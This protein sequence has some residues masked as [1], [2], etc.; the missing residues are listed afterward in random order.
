MAAQNLDVIRG[1][2]GDFLNGDFAGVMNRFDEQIEWVITEN[3]P[4]GGRF[5]GHEQVAAFFQ[6]L[7]QHYEELRVE[8]DEFVADGD[9][10]V[11][12]GVHRGRTRVGNEFEI[13]F[14]HAWML[15]D[16]K[17]LRFQEYADAAEFRKALGLD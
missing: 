6:A 15:R 4:F 17:A 8:P 7:D 10:V 12:L 2:Y 5:R 11:A 13:P 3:V 16:G 1:G 14:A 9:R